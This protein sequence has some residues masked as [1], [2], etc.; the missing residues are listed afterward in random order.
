[1][2]DRYARHRV[3]LHRTFGL[4]PVKERVTKMLADAI[5][6]RDLDRFHWRHILICGGFG[7]GKKTSAELLAELIRLVRCAATGSKAQYKV[8]Q[9]V[10]VFIKPN[11][12]PDFGFEARGEILEINHSKKNPRPFQVLVHSDHSENWHPERSIR[13]V[14]VDLD[15]EEVMQILPD[16]DFFKHNEIDPNTVYYFRVDKIAVE[17]LPP[18]AKLNELLKEIHARDSLVILGLDNDK[19]AA[20]KF[21]SL[22]Y[23]QKDDRYRRIDLD[24]ISFSVLAQITLQLIDA[25]GYQMRRRADEATAVK[26]G[27]GGGSSSSEQRAEGRVEYNKKL[28]MMEYIVRQ[29]F[30][31]EELKQ[32]NAHLA[33]I[34]LQRAISN[35]NYRV[36]RDQSI[37]P[38]V[39][40]P[41]DFGVEMQ[42]EEERETERVDIEKEAEHRW[43]DSS[44]AAGAT[45]SAATQRASAVRRTTRLTGGAQPAA[46]GT[47]QA[48]EPPTAPTSSLLGKS[49]QHTP[50]SVLKILRALLGTAA[51][52]AEA[53]LIG[54]KQWTALNFLIT[55]SSGTGKRRF[56][57]QLL[58][59]Y[60]KTY[61]EVG[62][63]HSKTAPEFVEVKV[64]RLQVQ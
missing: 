64:S 36:E 47:L 16:F 1:M 28:I 53:E 5:G 56:T 34:M 7:A 19:K 8:G 39:L 15:T 29:T 44:A 23:L 38:L 42:T 58:L 9:E 17:K 18:P 2:L 11:D 3:A 40:I 14:P 24:S 4:H 49:A 46:N 21:E 48:K 61:C 63:A 31:D 62:M 33:K 50:T 12:N 32:K 30:E 41:E 37:H 60:L 26:P 43:G 52:Q 10:L 59:P 35:K 55:G 54:T 45:A 13:P 57:K 51:A 25:Q 20:K 22:N 6:R 27:E